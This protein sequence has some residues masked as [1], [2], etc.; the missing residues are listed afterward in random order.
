MIECVHIFP[1]W[2]ILNLICLAIH[3]IILTQHPYKLQFPIRDIIELSVN[4]H[5]SGLVIIK[6]DIIQLIECLRFH[7]YHL[8]IHHPLA[9]DDMRGHE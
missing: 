9:G 7:S 3:E 6:T 2:H 4:T 1:T 5:D 8:H